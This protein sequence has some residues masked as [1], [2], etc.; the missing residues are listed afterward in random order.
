MTK[1]NAIN[2]LL[3]SMLGVT[4][5]S[6]KDKLL[7]VAIKRAYQDASSHVLS[8]SNKEEKETAKKA[9][10]DRIG[11]A[12]QE[13]LNGMTYDA[14][15]E[16][17][18]TELVTKIYSKVNQDP[19]RSFT[20]GIAQKWVNMTMKY[21]CVIK[22]I[23]EEYGKPNIVKWDILDAHEKE[24]HI[25]FDSF[26]LEAASDI[27]VPL[28]RKDGTLGKYS[29]NT[30]PWSKFN[31]YE[32]YNALQ[33]NLKDALDEPPLEWEGPAWI[34]ISERRKTPKTKK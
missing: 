18:C 29:A 24:L 2:F 21:L 32:E 15:H 28:P 27:D 25:P 4:L 13:G 20:Y 9:A 30:K 5:D 3:Y 33:S 10:S 31:T 23:F 6:N 34:R 1:E 11:R 12:I 14:W 26:I 22:N 17:L 8:I 19:D 16:G 7:E